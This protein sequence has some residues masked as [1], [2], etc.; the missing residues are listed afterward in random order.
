MLAVYLFT[1]LVGGALLGVSLLG[2][3]HGDVDSVAGHGHHT[4]DAAQFLSLRTLTYFLFVFGG[5][6]IALSLLT[7]TGWPLTL[8]LALLAGVGVGT[9]V[10]GTFRYL[11]RTDSGGNQSDDS[12]VGLSARVVLPI[13]EGG[14]GKVIVQ[15]GDRPMSCWQSHSMRRVREQRAGN[16]WW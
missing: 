1:V 6:G 4:H 9:I 16:P 11:S 2:S 12:F 3:D 15:R 14:L 5:V 7:R 10:T 8:V 13:A